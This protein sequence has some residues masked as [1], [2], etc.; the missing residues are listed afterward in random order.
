MTGAIIP[1]DWDGT[2]FNCQKVMWPS[3]VQWRAIL[4]GQLTEAEKEYF[5]DADFGVVA[6]AVQAIK[7]AETLTLPDFWTEECEDMPTIPVIAFKTEINTPFAISATTWTTIPWADYFYQHNNPGFDFV[8]SGHKPTLQGHLGVWHYDYNIAADVVPDNF[9]ARSR[10]LE[11][12]EIV[13]RLATRNQV[14]NLGF[15]YLWADTGYTLQTQVW[16]SIAAN[17]VTLI[18]HTH[19]SGHYVGPVSE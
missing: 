5:W 15:D 9:Q 18:G 14:I 1:D 10:I 6:D 12:G 11:T 13:A 3:S 16:S 19:Y 8:G 4:L 7:D 2:S 17:I